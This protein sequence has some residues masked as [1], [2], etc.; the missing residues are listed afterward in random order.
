MSL[1]LGTFPGG[2]AFAMP[3]KMFLRMFPPSLISALTLALANIADALVVGNR[4]GEAGLATIGLAT[5]VFLVFN[6]LGIGYASGGGITHARLTAGEERERALCHCRRLSAE[7]LLTGVVIAAAGILLMDAL[8]TG[9]GAGPDAPALRELCRAYVRPLIA[10]TPLFFLNFL[11][12]FFVLSDDNPALA[13]L[14]MS[15]GNILDLALNI[16]FVLVLH[17][18]VK[19]AVY[20]TVIAQAGSVLILSVHLFSARKGI[21]RLKAILS[22]KCSRRKIRFSRRDSLRAGFSSSVSYLFQFLFLLISNHL[23]LAAGAKGSMQGELAVAVFDIVMNCSFVTLSVYQAA[24]EA[25]QPLAATFSAEHD[26]QSLRWLLR[27]TLLAGLACGLILTVAVA[28]L[29]RPVSAAFG[30]TGREEQRLAARAIRIF[31]LSTPFAG[32]LRMLISY[33]Q[34]IG[35]VRTAAFASFLRNAAFLLPITLG[36]GIFLPS[37]FWWVFLLTEVLSLAVL[38]PLRAYRRKKTAGRSVPVLSL[39]MTNDNRELG[40]IV[41]AVE[42]FCGE[43][44]VPVSTAVQLQLAV[45]ELCAVTIAQAFS[46]KPEEYIRVTLAKERGPRYL[47]HIRNSAP[48]FNPLDMKMEK[49]RDGM[50]AEVMDSIGVMMVKK[51]AKNLSYRNYQGYNVMTVEY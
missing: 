12:Y 24:S 46:G 41:E 28:L 14:G 51:K 25:M 32:V 42:K 29:A 11:L 36:L 26:T 47:L 34:S 1:R 18:G 33:D 22:V 3:R 30:L 48:Y 20:A 37:A 17:W 43:N 45:E 6:L 21:L 49:A 39:T 7:L 44:E 35:R 38:L 19:G 23:L 13:S 8:L 2:S 27:I 16:L 5:P 10:A 50:T 15:V 31:L 40:T 4:V 9:L